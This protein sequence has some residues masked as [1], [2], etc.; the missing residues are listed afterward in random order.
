MQDG[1]FRPASEVTIKAL[2]FLSI[3]RHPQPKRNFS[4]RCD[5]FWRIGRVALKV[6]SHGAVYIHHR[7][8]G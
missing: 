4:W 5:S 7:R 8:R 1:G 6:G 2:T 3:S